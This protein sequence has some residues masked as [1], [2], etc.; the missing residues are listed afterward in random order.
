[1]SL[2]SSNDYSTASTTYPTVPRQKSR[3]EA[4]SRRGAP[5]TSIRGPR[6]GLQLSD[7]PFYL[8]QWLTSSAWYRAACLPL[9]T[10]SLEVVGSFHPPSPLY[11]SPP[12]SF[13]GRLDQFK[14]VGWVGEWGVQSEEPWQVR[15]S[16]VKTPITP[17][18]LTSISF[19]S[20]FR[21]L[22]V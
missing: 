10:W 4:S 17:G 1:M 3:M 6:Q 2:G 14:G 13:F 19:G 16:P 5:S 8:P 21:P 9:G 20:P 18:E 11:L 15:P 22:R 7:Q 12:S